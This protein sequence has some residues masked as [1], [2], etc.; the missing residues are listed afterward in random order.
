MLK[1]FVSSFKPALV[2]LCM[3][4]AVATAQPAVV[5]AGPGIAVDS[6]DLNVDAQRI[7]LEARKKL[8]T[9]PENVAQMAS[10]LYV[11]RALTVEAERA[12]LANDPMVAAAI[13]L[14]K[15]RILS[16][17]MMAQLD[18]KNTP[19]DDALDQ[20]ALARYRVNIKQYETP[21]QIRA[22]HILIKSTTPETKEKAKEKAK[23]ILSELKNGADFES[24]AKTNSEDATASKGGDLGFFP[25]GRMIAPFEA[26]AFALE[27]PGDFSE[28]VETE[29]GFHIIKLEA[30]QEATVKPFEEVRDQLRKETLANLL[31]DGRGRESQRLLNEAKFEQ[32]AIEAFA[33][34]QQ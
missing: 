24:L 28:V 4:H 30:K 23:N 2:A 32:S 1:L 31:S 33:K 21:A 7:P 17:A 22:R 10:N 18:I 34:G 14:A 26:A 25:R 20:F 5:V 11:R 9:K 29:F 27:K 3:V 12:G 15:E 16:D 19:P 6:S 13:R 8:L